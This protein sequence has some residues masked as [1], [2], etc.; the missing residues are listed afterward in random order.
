M[1]SKLQ[2]RKIHK[3]DGNTVD[4][5]K[6]YRIRSYTRI[7]RLIGLLIKLLNNL[8]PYT[9]NTSDIGCRNKVIGAY[10]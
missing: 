5:E 8:S 6:N 4:Q 2:K 1:P 10:Y 7:I 3:K 9:I